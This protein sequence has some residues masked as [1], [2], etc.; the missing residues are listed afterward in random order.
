MAVD[1]GDAPELPGVG[2]EVNRVQLAEARRMARSVSSSASSGGD[3]ER[4]D[5]SCA[6]ASS[7]DLWDKLVSI[8][9]A[10]RKIE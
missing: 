4:L 7:G 3:G 6:L 10:T 1:V 5:S 2:D 8:A 9:P